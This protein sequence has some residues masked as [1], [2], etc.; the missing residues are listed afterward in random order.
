MPGNELTHRPRELTHRDDDDGAGQRHETRHEEPTLLWRPSTKQRSC[1]SLGRRA[2]APPGVA[3]VGRGDLVVSDGVAQPVV[4][5]SEKVPQ[6][7]VVEQDRHETR[8]G[9]VSAST[10]S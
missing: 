7:V 2:L 4:T 3:E 8:S 6:Q 1:L 5:T 9:S 10:R